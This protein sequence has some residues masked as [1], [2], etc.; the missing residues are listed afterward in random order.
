LSTPGTA[1]LVS[2]FELYLERMF[3]D[4][5]ISNKEPTLLA[6]STSASY[7]SV[8][9]RGGAAA[10]IFFQSEFPLNRPYT[11]WSVSDLYF[12]SNVKRDQDLLSMIEFRP[13]VIK[14]IRG[15]YNYSSFKDLLFTGKSVR[16]NL[17]S[18]IFEDLG[19]EPNH[20]EDLIDFVHKKAKVHAIREPLKVRLITKG[21]TYKYWISRWFQKQIWRLLRNWKQFTLIG[22]PVSAEIIT[23]ILDKSRKEFELYIS[24]DYKSAT[25]NLKIQ[26]TRVCFEKL[27]SLYSLDEEYKQILREVLYEHTLEYPLEDPELSSFEQQRGQLM[28]STLSFPILCLVNFLVYWISLEEYSKEAY[29]PSELPVL[30]NGDDVLFKSN[31]VHYQVWKE[32]AKEVGF[33]LS[34]GKNYISSSFMMINSM[35]FT[36]NMVEIPWFNVGLLTGQSKL[37]KIDDI[38]PIWDYYNFVLWGAKN[39][40]RAHRRFF[41]YHKKWISSLTFKGLF[42]VFFDHKLSGLGFTHYEEIPL[43]TT[44]LQR[45]F[46]EFLYNYQRQDFSSA[47]PALKGTI[48][49]F[50]KVKTNSIDTSLYHF[51]NYRVVPKYHVCSRLE[52][53]P[54]KYELSGDYLHGN[55][56]ID[57]PQ[58]D[59]RGMDVR[60]PKDLFRSFKHS[61]SKGKV[62]TKYLSFPYKIIEQL[63]SY[64]GFWELNHPKRW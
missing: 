32:I 63:S 16:H 25:D 40:L 22:Q 30:V 39:K 35:G 55:I 56:L 3:R 7:E 9:S 5:K 41:H 26:Y 37:G 60:F 48:V 23:D 19:L 45:N 6:P 33:E 49:L 4:I 8:R 12:K 28:G 44:R 53:E 54:R 18:K 50:P 62:S 42:N 46:A 10:T 38:T 11:Q 59:D 43:K 14:E 15:K 21:N 27:L 64:M 47:D 29:E 61:I 36:S 2:R 1:S 51:G 20:Q 17:S 57:T 13:G 24:G 52:C 58:G 34:V 31:T